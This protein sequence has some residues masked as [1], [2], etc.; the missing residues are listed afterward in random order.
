MEWAGVRYQVGTTVC[1]F[2]RS[3]LKA[4]KW[5]K[6]YS[7]HAGN[8]IDSS[9]SVFKD[10]L[11]YLIHAFICSACRWMAWMFS[12]FSRGQTISKLQKPF[13]NSSLSHCLLPNTYFQHFKSFCTI[14]LH[15]KA[16]LYATSSSLKSPISRC[17]QIANRKHICMSKDN[18]EQSYMLQQDM[19]KQTVSIHSSRSR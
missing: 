13:K 5:P 12:I 9:S 3:F 17:I 8:F 18:T 11:D 7:W 19:T 2:W 4:L 1:I 14:T 15:L 10:K 6:W 16:T